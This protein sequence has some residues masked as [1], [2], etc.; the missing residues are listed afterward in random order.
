M[1]VDALRWAAGLNGRWTSEPSSFVVKGPLKL[2][3]SLP[4]AIT[5]DAKGVSKHSVLAEDPDCSPLDQH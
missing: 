4:Y 5:L 1:L 2:V 3:F